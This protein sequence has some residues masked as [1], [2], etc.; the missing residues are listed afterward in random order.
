MRD[1]EPFEIKRYS[2]RPKKTN[3]SLNMTHPTKTNL[4]K[5]ISRFILLGYITSSGRL[6]FRLFFM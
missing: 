4:Y 5:N 3:L 1:D 6:V 2:L